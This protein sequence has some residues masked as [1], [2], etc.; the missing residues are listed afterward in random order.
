MRRIF[1][2]AQRRTPPKRHRHIK[3]TARTFTFLP[4]S[5][6]LFGIKTV[7]KIRPECRKPL[8]YKAF[9]T[10]VYYFRSKVYINLYSF[11]MV[12]GAFLRGFLLCFISVI[13]IILSKCC[14]KCCH[15][16]LSNLQ[17]VAWNKTSKPLKNLI[18]LF[19]LA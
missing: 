19:P 12:L 5:I 11:R 15:T 16:K 8:I 1:K 14:Q 2:K 4:L 17:K 18:R 7:S 13:P 9:S 3:T 10:C 6:I